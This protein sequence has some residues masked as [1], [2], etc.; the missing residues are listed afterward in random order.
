MQDHFVFAGFEANM[1][2]FFA[3]IDVF[4]LS[5]HGEGFPLAI[6]EA[7]YHAKPVV[8]TR[9]AAFPRRSVRARQAI[10]FLLA[11]PSSSQTP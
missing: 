1:E 2:R 7:M 9:W 3:A 4:A 11:L 10:S 6:I 5:T 8:A